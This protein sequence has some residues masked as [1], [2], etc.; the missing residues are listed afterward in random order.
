MDYQRVLDE[1]IEVKR[2]VDEVFAYVAEF[3]NIQEWD[4]GVRSASKLTTGSARVGSRF[5]VVMKLGMPLRYE[6]REMAE[7]ERL[8]LQAESK[9]FTAQEEIL[10]CASGNGRT[11]VRYI[12]RFQLS[13]PLAA[14]DTVYPAAMDR[15]GKSAMDGLRAAL[16]D[17]QDVPQLPARLQLADELLLPG[18][19]RFSR[20]GY[21]ASSAR[22]KPVSADLRSRHIV[23]TGAT[24]GLGLA[25]ANA[26]AER[27]AQLTLV[28]RDAV[29]G[30][31]LCAQLQRDYDNATIALEICDLA[32]MN[33]TVALAQRLCAQGRPIDVLINNA[34]ALFN[35]RQVT[36]EGY[37]RSFALLLLAPF[38]LTELLHPLLRA[39]SGARVINVSS[40]GM[41]SQKL[42]AQ[43]LQFEHGEYSGPAAY[44]RAK[45]GL[46]I[47][48]EEWAKRWADDGIVVNAMHPG[49]ADTPGVEDSLP[50]FHRLAKKILRTPEQ[51]ADTIVWLAAATEAGRVSGKFWLDREPHTTH[52]L[53]RTR[54]SLQERFELLGALQNELAS[55]LAD[56]GSSSMS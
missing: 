54:E 13:T 16:E 24:S 1:T 4:P 19:L 48:G 33:D 32:L 55:V 10:F 46:V 31:A 2:P 53:S 25:T 35:S 9:L 45:R 50:G 44:A 14:L 37:E 5:R 43:D 15:V 39:A 49:W 41:Y 29:K 17:A 22:F 42:A 8:L 52:L 23:I 38:I 47:V 40:G 26:L 36:A 30:E 6:I 7:G 56:S 12:A 11:T 28:V 3:A 20:L 18:L 21:S 34:G 27:G 51:G